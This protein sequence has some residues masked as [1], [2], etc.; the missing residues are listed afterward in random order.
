MRTF[1]RSAVAVVCASLL[2][3]GSGGEHVPAGMEFVDV[4][5]TVATADGKPLK[6]GTIHFA[7]A[8]A[9]AGRE[10]MCVVADGK[11]NLKMAVG[12]YK[13]GFNMRAEDGGA[14]RS[15]LPAKYSKFE[16]SQLDA[17]ISKSNATLTFTLK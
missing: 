8:E 6:A 4:T 3:C 9:G 1:L 14:V 11:F 7:P 15:T 2:G 17:D 13:V 16:T 10:E 5:G 12:K